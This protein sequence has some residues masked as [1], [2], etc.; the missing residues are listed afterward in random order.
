MPH[1]TSLL[2]A[3]PGPRPFALCTGHS[4]LPVLAPPAR[5][6]PEEVRPR[7]LV[8]ILDTSGSMSW[9]P[10]EKSKAVVQK[11]IDAMRPNDTFNVITFAGRTQVLWPEPRTASEENRTAAQRFIDGLEGGGGTEMMAAIEAALR[12]DGGSLPGPVELANQP[13][14]GRMVSIATAYS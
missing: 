5:V 1:P 13:A 4:E 2:P 14:D 10:I 8:F 9:F 3:V 12:Q 6:V 7:E 11:A